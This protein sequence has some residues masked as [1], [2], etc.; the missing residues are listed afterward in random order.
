M[1][2]GSSMAL[3]RTAIKRIQASRQWVLIFT[4]MVLVSCSVGHSKGA[5]ARTT[6]PSLKPIGTNQ[7]CEILKPV[8]LN[9]ILAPKGPHFER[10]AE[11]GGMRRPL[12]SCWY[13]TSSGRAIQVSLYLET[14]KTLESLPKVMPRGRNGLQQ[15]FSDYVKSHA[16]GER[17]SDAP[18][19]T[20]VWIA[21]PPDQTRGRSVWSIAVVTDKSYS[22]TVIGVD[23]NVNRLRIE[24]LASQIVVRQLHVDGNSD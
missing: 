19:G 5:S 22:M 3:R 13:A 14:L 15:A 12:L 2:N 4:C 8:D 20:A 9:R 24:S 6:L 21:L 23:A 17:L 10:V 18:V 11:N 1:R 16:E 7:A